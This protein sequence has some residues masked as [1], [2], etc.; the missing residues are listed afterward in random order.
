MRLEWF[1]GRQGKGSTCHLPL[2]GSAFATPTCPTPAS[3]HTILSSTRG[4]T[5]THEQPP[6]THT[7]RRTPIRTETSSRIYIRMHLTLT[8]TPIHIPHPPHIYAPRDTFVAMQLHLCV[9]THTHTC[10]RVFTHMHG[11]PQTARIPNVP[12]TQHYCGSSRLVFV[13][14]HLRY[15]LTSMFLFPQTYRLSCFLS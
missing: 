8:H 2:P 7:H 15:F 4:L 13:C 1:R 10:T 5:R 11:L 9:H 14:K 3:V 12:N 6:A